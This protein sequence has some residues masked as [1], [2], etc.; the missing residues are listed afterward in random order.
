MSEKTN[1]NITP[2]YDDYD[3]AKR[4]HKIL[5]RAGRP[6]QARE[7]TQS[8]S[9]LQDQV[10][11]FGGHFF[12]EGSVIQGAES[13]IDMDIYFVKV[14][15]ANPNSSGDASVESYRTTTHGQFIRGK[16]TGVVAKVI[17]SDQATST[18][19]ATLYVKPF[20]MGTDASGS[21]LFAG[22]E[23][24]EVVNMSDDG[25]GTLTDAAT[26]NDFKT[27]ST[28]EV[29]SGR[30]S[31]ASIS[32]GTIYTRGFF[33]KVEPQTIVLEK[34]SGK[35]SFRVG[36]EI[37]ESL[38]SS[39]EDTTL[40]DN[41]QG[42]N[43]ENAPGADRLKFTL[44]LAKVALDDSTNANFIELGRVNNGIIELEINRPIYNT[45][46]ETLARRTFDQSGDF[47]VRQFST[48]FRE[49][50][51]KENNRGFLLASDGG[52]EEQFVLQVSPGKA[53][54]KGFEIEKLGTTNL[55]FNKARTTGTV[56]N[57]STPVRIGN[58][59]RVNSLHSLPE[60]ADN[61]N[62][63]S[64]VPINLH[65]NVRN[66]N[67]VTG[68]HIG[69]CR[70]RHFQ[71]VSNVATQASDTL[72]LYL[73]DIKMFTEIT[74][75]SF[76]SGDFEVG[77]KVEN[78]QGA[79][80]IIAV[81]DHSNNKL[82]IHDV[83]GTFSASQTISA[84]G[85]DSTSKTISAVRTYNI[86]Q[87]RS[88]FQSLPGNGTQNFCAN[89]VLDAFTQ[90]SGELN[91]TGGNA[92]VEGT[93]T[94][95]S[96]ELV[97]GD[98]IVVAGVTALVSGFDATTPETKMTI[99]A[100]NGGA[101]GITSQRNANVLRQR[102]QLRDP[103]QTAAIFAWPRDHVKTITPKQ[104]NVTIRKQIR[105]SP[106]S[107]SISIPLDNSIEKFAT[108]SALTFQYAVIKPDTGGGASLSAGQVLYPADISS[109]PTDV[110]SA[111]TVPIG[112]GSDDDEAEILVSY[113]VIKKDPAVRNKDLKVSRS[114]RFASANSDGKRYGLAFDHKDLSLGVP[115]VF[116]VHAVLEGVPGTLT[117]GNPTPPN[118]TLTESNSSGSLQQNEILIGQTSG[119]KVRL[120]DTVGDTS[121][122]ILLNDTQLIN[123][124]AVVG[125]TTKAVHV[126]SNVSAGSPNIKDRYFLDNGQRDGY[127]DLSR[128][129]LKT[130]SQSPN[131]VVTVIFDHFESGTGDYYAV[132]SYNLG[133]NSNQISYEDIPNYSP[134]KVDLGGFEP[135]GQFELSD[136]VDFRS[137]VNALLTLGNYD[138]T[139]VPNMSAV[140]TSPFAYA[141]RVF[142]DKEFNTPIPGTTVDADIS[143]YVPRIDRVFL[144][145]TG[146]FEVVNGY[147]DITP[148]K[149][150]PVDNAIEMFEL[151]V[152]AYTK[153]VKDIS[154]QAKDYRR[155]TMK[156]IG[157]ISNRVTNLERITSL[158]LLEK[159]SLSKQILDADGLDRFK[160]GFLVDNFR[161][162][163]IGD[164]SH[165]DYRVAIDTKRGILRP[166][167][168]TQFFDIE[169]NNTSS[170]NFQK[171]GDLITLPYTEN[172]FVE[173]DKASRSLNVNPY[174][175]FAFIG[176]VELTPETDVW[177]D[178]ETLPEVRI[179]REG[180]FDAVL[181]ENQNSIGTIWN[182]W[183]TTWVG[184][185]EV[186]GEE[187]I[188]R[189][190]SYDGNPGQGGELTPTV[191]TV[192]REITE[193]PEGQIRNGIKTS[194]VEEFVE[195][196]NDRI[197]SISVIPFC[198]E[199]TI[200]I[201]AT[202]LKPQTV[203]YVFFDGIRVDEYVRPFDTNYSNDGHTGAAAL[204]KT[205]NNGRLRAF[206]DLPNNRAQKFP[207][208]QRQM[209]ITS[210][211]TDLPQPAS[212]GTGTYQ[213][214][215]LL[216]TSQTEIVSTRNGRVVTEHLS[217]ERTIVKKGERYNT[218]VEP[219]NTPPSPPPPPPTTP[220]PT[221]PD[222]TP[223]PS[224]S[225]TPTPAPTTSPQPSPTPTPTKPPLESPIPTGPGPG[226]K[227]VEQQRDQRV[228]SN[229]ER[230]RDER[231]TV[232]RDPLA[233][234]FLVESAGGA[235]MTSV[236]VFF[237]T[238][239]KNLPVSVEI[240][241]MVNGYPGQIILPFS[242]VTK[243]PADV[244]IS[245]D[246]SV[247]TTFTFP[248]PV[249]IEDGKEMCFVVFSN[250]NEYEAHIS[251]MGEPDLITGETISGQPYG[252]SLFKSQNSSTWTAEQTDDLK[253]TLRQ[254]KFDVTKV[255]ALQ[256][257]NKHLPS[258]RLQPNPIVTTQGESFIKVLN[259]GHG[260]YDTS[261][262]VKIVSIKGD[263]SN[264]ALKVTSSAVSGDV[265]NSGFNAGS[266]TFSLT[267]SDYTYGSGNTG[268]GLKLDV[269]ILQSDR[270]AVS[271]IFITDPGVGYTTQTFTAT[272]ETGKTITVTIDKV[273]DTLGGLPI[274]LMNTPHGALEDF[275]IDNFNLDLN[276]T[277]LP[278][279]NSN[280]LSSS[281]YSFRS[282][283]GAVE[284]TQGGGDEV[285]CTRNIYYDGLHTMIPS[286]KVAG[287]EIF[288][289]CYRTGMNSPEFELS[290]TS[291]HLDTAYAMRTTSNFIKLNDNAYF[292]RPS[293]V[294]SKVN[295]EEEMGNTK[296]FRLLLQLR[297]SNANVSPV[298]DTGTIG[299][300]GIMN[301]INNINVSGDVSNG[302]V[303]TPLTEPDG[304]N[305][306]MV[307]I[308]RK[309]QL[310]T[311]ATSLKVFADNFRPP[312]TDLKYMFKII[313]QDEQ[314]PVDDIGFE[315]FNSTGTSDA[316]IPNDGRNFKEYEYT[317]DNLPEFSAF[318]IKIVGQSSNTCNVPL[319]SALRCMALA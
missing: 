202:N 314:T 44:T 162:H 49:H 55:V 181:A 141:S 32:S 153:N 187:V 3:E 13:N 86:S 207:T 208:G 22:D 186:V 33:V 40:L 18:D 177:Q 232:W 295:E 254:A 97:I 139:S 159:D 231:E 257:E 299:V 174:H 30:A 146:E 119:A 165:P 221:V 108:P 213:A 179:N 6:L 270:D 67:A 91:I 52:Q 308:T 126:V 69:F 241:N 298:I 216:Q 185:P 128:L 71:N 317:A 280:N 77:D 154:V 136:A 129:Q 191:T 47:V 45:F 290:D 296:S 219:G 220:V 109:H 12:K 10:E 224:P 273:G 64:F 80:G 235:F 121:F 243:N 17:T 63:D 104:N 51:L 281:E 263:K 252:G 255:P 318:Q 301:R 156:D 62:T 133:E 151:F 206:F 279:T 272:L 150:Q 113:T 305:N 19:P 169:L 123:N 110:N 111:M 247:A 193:T 115:D 171:T 210:S 319:V 267:D 230:F 223:T 166:Q 8:Q 197:V 131:N 149:P 35:P 212:Y 140:T 43:N 120:I 285:V 37:V 227:I 215:G 249:Y 195:T 239:D 144:H 92:T 26:N 234:S 310:K 228:A 199:R 127:Y 170:T 211:A 79:T 36:V 28:L 7:L 313:K 222:P 34:Y 180:N 106:S 81:A 38:I 261:S 21:F 94:Q 259:Y 256:F 57:T 164:V 190:E 200:E 161:G 54:V 145:Q 96:K 142:S 160:S 304:D 275:A 196:R 103:D 87:A 258:R 287:T 286:T 242:T 82:F 289:T 102:S 217:G 184:E 312:S 189:T 14:Q 122:Y 245:A 168:D 24:I 293:I 99:T 85:Q 46:E 118:A 303:F 98:Q 95:F 260:M 5:Y 2:Y 173:Q 107:G 20:N 244:N 233:E 58:R 42:T 278:F 56:T 302:E 72:D 25:N 59:L 264:G 183:Q 143:F 137:P 265:A 306:A 201:D 157:K 68:T 229:N 292:D 266:K 283:Y 89:I 152:P 163:K 73:F 271:N 238:K 218:T 262:H 155:Y 134:N 101:H 61:N 114:V 31:I 291:T 300:L 176:N 90:L 105:L 27:V 269:E 297:S 309:V 284:S 274:E 188:S 112:S 41:A 130:G 214:Q 23:E 248:S 315:F 277:T 250:S 253:F 75:A 60:I 48:S 74:T 132:S 4:F 1:L 15:S 203:H 53:Y 204:V 117:N 78:Q 65:D 209:R 93:A 240:R 182:A 307:Y 205:D 84:R 167:H 66:G 147:P 125:Q 16:T 70:A 100:T 11:K 198:R 276:S 76:N 236:D 194:V 237:K 311:P 88:V 39:S 225:A 29:P 294:A 83:V 192:T 158:S 251:R 175:V 316:D 268:A 148:Q 226:G 50:L 288:A 178:T 135:D 172:V 116:K 138:Q 282:T 9:I 124:E 246:G